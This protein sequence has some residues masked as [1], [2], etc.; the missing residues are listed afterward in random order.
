VKE[1]DL[2]VPV[3]AVLNLQSLV[4]VAAGRSPI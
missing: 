4:S 2:V 3:N 1:I